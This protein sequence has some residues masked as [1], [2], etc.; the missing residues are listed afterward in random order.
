[1]PRKLPVKRKRK[2]PDQ[3]IELY[4]A[5]SSPLIALAETM[6]MPHNPVTVNALKK[7][8]I[9]AES[10]VEARFGL[11]GRNLIADRMGESV[12]LALYNWRQFKI[13]GGWY[14]PDWC[15]HLA[16][17]R[18]VYVEVKGSKLQANYRDARTHLRAAASLN[19][20]YTFFEAMPLP[21]NEGGGWSLELIEPDVTFAHFLAQCSQFL[22]RE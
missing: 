19:P 5:I 10:S 11:C 3:L 13:P 1:M 15:Y 17:G 4:G 2:T 22:E 12:V 6:C 8:F 16:D 9:Q 20:M 21:A 18:E 14:T 7:F